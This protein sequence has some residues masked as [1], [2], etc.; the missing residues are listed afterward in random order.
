M[1]LHSV[2]QTNVHP[3]QHVV[4]VESL[5]AAQIIAKLLA[6]RFPQSSFSYENGGAF[7]R[8]DSHP[9]MRDSARSFEVQ[10]LVKQELAAE[11]DNPNDLPKWIVSFFDSRETVHKCWQVNST[12]DHDTQAI[13]RIK[14]DPTFRGS[15]VIFADYPTPETTV[16]M[17]DAFAAQQEAA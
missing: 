4:L 13:K 12:F 15:Q 9:A 1:G 7:N 11:T 17:L 6:E 8:A 3:K 2:I 5:R 14:S 10:N 16:L